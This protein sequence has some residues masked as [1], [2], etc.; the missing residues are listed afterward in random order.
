MPPPIPR[1]PG[2]PVPADP[3]TLGCYQGYG[4]RD[5]AGLLAAVRDVIRFEWD[6][7]RGGPTTDVVLL[8][9][10]LSQFMN[11]MWAGKV[12]PGFKRDVQTNVC[13]MDW[14]ELACWANWAATLDELG[15]SFAMEELRRGNPYPWTEIGEYDWPWPPNPCDANLPNPCDPPECIEHDKA[16]PSRCLKYGR[17]VCEQDG[18]CP[19]TV[20]SDKRY[21]VGYGQYPYD[22]KAT[23][24]SDN[25][26]I[27]V[28]I[29]IAAIVGVVAL[30]YSTQ[31]RGS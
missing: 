19:D 2:P 25:T 27:L 26:G 30:T 6:R 5:V 7:R 21:A 1:P 14:I 18:C 12:I 4:D 13:V 10:R 31:N 22:R 15:R 24:K 17:P 29:G 3:R 28:A 11:A 9:A 16:D 8:E 23:A 20:W